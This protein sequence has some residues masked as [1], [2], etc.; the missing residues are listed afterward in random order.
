MYFTLASAAGLAG[1]LLIP[2]VLLLILESLP[3]LAPAALWESLTSAAWHPR[4][5]EFGL[6]A[7]MVASLLIS[8]LALALAAPLGILYAV[9]LN[10]YLP[11]RWTN[12]L[13][14]LQE[15]L[16]GIP[17]V[18]YGLWGLVVLV[19]MINSYAPP[20]ASLLAAV[21]VLALMILPFS[22][23]VTDAALQ[24]PIRHRMSAAQALA[25]S[26]WGTFRRVL[27]PEA[28]ATIIGGIVLQFGRALGETLAVVM[29]AG[30]VVQFPGSLFDPV[31]T[32]TANIA[33]EMSYAT[34]T[35]HTALFLSGLVLM[36]ITLILMFQINRRG[37]AI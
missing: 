37:V 16:A 34:G 30:N 2:V 17:S 5:G 19:P 36:L 21:L 13:R 35:H 24:A 29:V 27:W 25:V 32:L 20:G 18:V 3:L 23:L 15:L 28:R 31:R 10:L 4:A 8:A 14:P 6:L 11:R 1:L 26:R 7:M 12:R 22:A 9:W 33:L